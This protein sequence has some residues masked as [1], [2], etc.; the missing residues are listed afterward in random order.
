MAYSLAEGVVHRWLRTV[1]SYHSP[2]LVQHLD[3]V[4]PHW[5]E[6]AQELSAQQVIT[7]VVVITTITMQ[8]SYCLLILYMLYYTIA[9]F[10]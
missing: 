9:F 7:V 3:R 10:F 8:T 6:A 2:A 5:E 1:L 4:L